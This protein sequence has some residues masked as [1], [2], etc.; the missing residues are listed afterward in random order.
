VLTGAEDADGGVIDGADVGGAESPATRAGGGA[1]V[2][3]APGVVGKAPV[4]GR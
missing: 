3:R 1:L 4:A 2:G